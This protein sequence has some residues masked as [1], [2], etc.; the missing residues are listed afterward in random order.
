[1][2]G[3]VRTLGWL[4]ILLATAVLGSELFTLA[5]TGRFE[6]SSLGEVWNGF[7]PESLRVVQTSVEGHVS[8]A[9]WN[10][11]LAPLLPYKAVL[12]FALPGVV[13]AALPSL[14]ELVNR[15]GEP[16]LS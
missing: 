12:V 7:H 3:T 16:D 4:L 13:L 8:V 15:T 5:D 2:S 14:I 9:L 10:D 1:M 6:L 11:L